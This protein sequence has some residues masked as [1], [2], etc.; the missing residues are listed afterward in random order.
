MQPVSLAM[1]TDPFR[2]VSR[3]RTQIRPGISTPSLHPGPIITPLDRAGLP[4]ILFGRPAHVAKKG[5]A[6]FDDANIGER[7]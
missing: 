1:M 4:I 3:G 6:G 5:S 2:R 7:A